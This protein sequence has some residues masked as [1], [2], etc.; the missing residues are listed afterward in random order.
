MH[1]QLSCL[2]CLKCQVRDSLKLNTIVVV[3]DQAL[4]AKAAEIK[5]KHS[6]HFGDDIPR[7]GAYDLYVAKNI[8]KEVP[9]SWFERSVYRVPGCAAPQACIQSPDEE[10]VVR[11]PDVDSREAQREEVFSRQ[12]VC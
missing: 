6:E 11:I 10:S 1:P 12:C 7:M 3:F 8:R 4:Y 9:G 2:Q 5:W